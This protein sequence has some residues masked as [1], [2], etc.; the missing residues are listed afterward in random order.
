MYAEIST[1]Q[2][3]LPFASNQWVVIEVDAR[4]AVGTYKG[5]GILFRVGGSSNQD[6]ILDLYTDPDTT[7]ATGDGASSA[8]IRSWRKLVKLSGSYSNL[9]TF[10]RQYIMNWW[11]SEEHTSELQSLMRISYAVFCLKKK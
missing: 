10:I 8:A 7:G 9:N 4:L 5:S 2:Y 3:R 11:I 1:G 6:A